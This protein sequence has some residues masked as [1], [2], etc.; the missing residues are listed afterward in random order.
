MAEIVLADAR[1][2]AGLTISELAS[3]ARTSETTVL[4]FCRRLGLPGYPQLR[5]ALAEESAHPR[6]MSRTITDISATD[7]IDDVIAKVAFTDASAV[8]ETA[9]QLDRGALVAAATAIA[10]AGRV[11]IYGIAASAIVGIDLQQKLHRIGVV[12]FVWNDPHIAL[13]SATLLGRGDVA[14]GISHSGTTTETIESLAAARS[15]GATTVAIT[16]FPVSRLANGADILLTTA[17]RETSLRS[18]ATASRIAALTV[19]DCL[20]IAVAQRNLRRARKALLDTREAVAGHHV[21][22]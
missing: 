22:D 15:A 17:A 21:A 3:A 12:A 18:G 5:L 10:K 9:Q 11:D 13:T 8:E 16:N 6:T 20:Y 4:R 7:T 1:R 2:A 19:V 14:V